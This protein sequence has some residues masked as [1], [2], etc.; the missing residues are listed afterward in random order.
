MAVFALWSGGL[1][2]GFGVVA[3]IAADRLGPVRLVPYVL[4]CVLLVL[5][6]ARTAVELIRRLRTSP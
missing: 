2:V 4:V 5:M 6:S 1:G 3:A